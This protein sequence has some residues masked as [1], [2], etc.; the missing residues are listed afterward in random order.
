MSVI[1]IC[2]NICL[3]LR[4]SNYFSEYF[5]SSTVNEHKFYHM[6][7]GST[8]DQQ[9]T[10]VVLCAHSVPPKR[11]IYGHTGKVQELEQLPVL[12]EKIGDIY[13]K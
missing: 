3:P 12:K 4:K 6:V 13:A 7:T 5:F 9:V 11:L 1:D 2:S 8:A 10:D